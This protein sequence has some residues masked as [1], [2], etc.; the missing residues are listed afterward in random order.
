M[1]TVRLTD[2][3]SVEPL[4]PIEVV[5][6][7]RPRACGKFLWVGSSKFWVRGATYGAFRPDAQKREYQDTAVIDRD[8]AQMAGAGFNT[9]RIP[10]T[11]PP[12]HLLDIAARHGL[13]VM[14]GLS[15]EQYAGYLADP[16]DA[17]DRGAPIISGVA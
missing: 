13:R 16:D 7:G 12:R 14:V 1:G 3:H 8:F 10:H 2:M 11:R 6:A 17:P 15:A 4:T 9:V 5:H